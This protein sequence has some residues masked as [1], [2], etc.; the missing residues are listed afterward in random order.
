MWLCLRAAQGS[1]GCL[2]EETVLSILWMWKLSPGGTKRT[3]SPARPPIRHTRSAW[4]PL[5]H[6][7]T[8]LCPRS[9]GFSA[10]GVPPPQEGDTAVHMTCEGRSEPRISGTPAAPGTTGD[11]LSLLLR[12]LCS[13]LLS[14][15][16][17]QPWATSTQLQ[18]CWMRPGHQ[19]PAWFGMAVGKV[20]LQ[21]GF[22]RTELE[23]GLLI[24]GRWAGP[25]ETPGR[26]SG[27]VPH[28][29]KPWDPGSA[30]PQLGSRPGQQSRPLPLASSHPAQAIPPCGCEKV[31]V[32][33]TRGSRLCGSIHIR[34]DQG[35]R[36]TW[37]S[38]RPL[39]PT[40]SP[41]AT[42]AGTRPPPAWLQGVQGAREAPGGALL[43]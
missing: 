3:S 31:S 1:P 34:K 19:V 11:T 9:Y 24:T 8:G 42:T 21:P 37:H 7:C 25:W 13:P 4:A 2:E 38:C 15:L 17:G 41:T 20:G 32:T 5:G 26:S 33:S 36:P 10:L 6:S 18:G 29:D 12:F 40:G 35:G 39:L 28:Q 14:C 22:S 43:I 30:S 27:P 16:P 23:R